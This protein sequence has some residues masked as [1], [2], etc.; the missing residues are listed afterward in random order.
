MVSTSD[1]LSLDFGSTPDSSKKWTVSS[2]GRATP[3]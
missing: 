2:V 1:F 3:F